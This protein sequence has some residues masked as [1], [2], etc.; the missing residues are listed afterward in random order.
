MLNKAVSDICSC[1]SF[2]FMFGLGT[3]YIDQVGLEV[4][5]ILLPQ[6][7]GSWNYMHILP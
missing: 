7:S 1:F 5:V 2:S 3:F 4:I 6:D